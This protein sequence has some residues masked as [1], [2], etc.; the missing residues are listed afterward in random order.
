[1]KRIPEPALVRSILVAVT[2][3]IALLVGHQTD[4]SWIEAAVTGY[5]AISPI[6]AG[7]LIRQAVTPAR[8]GR[9]EPDETG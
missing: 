2:G 8:V 9:P 1:M 3:V 5:A 6:I 7:V 4:T